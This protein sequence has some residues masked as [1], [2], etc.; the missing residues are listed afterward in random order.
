MLSVSP[1]VKVHSLSSVLSFLE[2]PWDPTESVTSLRGCTPRYSCPTQP[3]PPS[4]AP[5]ARTP[6]KVLTASHSID[7]RPLVAT[8]QKLTNKS[9]VQSCRWPHFVSI[10]ICLNHNSPLCA[11]LTKIVAPHKASAAHDSGER[12]SSE[13]ASTTPLGTPPLCTLAVR[14]TSLA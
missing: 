9:T 14:S 7:K 6:W 3:P 5:A 13:R 11:Q 8:E 1:F 10:L 4:A 2:L 12:K